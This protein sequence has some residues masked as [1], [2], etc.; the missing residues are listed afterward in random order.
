MDN[1]R[2]SSKGK[3]IPQVQVGGNTTVALVYYMELSHVKYFISLSTKQIKYGKDY[4]IC[5]IN[6]FSL[7]HHS[8]F[9]TTERKETNCRL[10]SELTMASLK[11]VLFLLF[12]VCLA[13]DTTFTLWH[14]KTEQNVWTEG[15]RSIKGKWQQP[16]IQQFSKW[17]ITWH[18]LKWRN[19]MVLWSYPY[20]HSAI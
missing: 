15:W 9:H 19:R 20:R 6:I 3:S 7:G 12:S 1:N 5:K 18:F 17:W 8:W 16:A 2:Y 14:L 13:D 10:L 4:V 11:K